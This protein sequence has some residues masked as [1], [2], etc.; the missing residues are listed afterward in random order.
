LRKLNQLRFAVK[1]EYALRIRGWKPLRDSK[2]SRVIRVKADEGQYVLKTLFVDEDRQR[3]I[4]EAEDYLRTQGIRIPKGVETRTGKPLFVWK[5]SP[6]VLQQW[7]CGKPYPLIAKDRV[8][9]ASTLLGSVHA[10]SLGFRGYRGE[11]YV[12]ACQWEEEYAADLASMKAWREKHRRL[13]KHMGLMTRI[14]LRDIDYFRK[15]A[16]RMQEKLKQNPYFAVWKE[17]PLSEHYLCHGDFHT[18]NVIARQEGSGGSD[19]G[20]N[21]GS[22]GSMLSIIDWE[23]VRYDFPS[24]DITRL[25]FVMMRRDKGWRKKRFETL[26]TAYLQVN[27]LTDEQKSLLYTDMAFPHIFERFLR[28]EQYRRM[29]LHE[30]RRFLKGERQKTAY[31]EHQIGV[32]PPS[33]FKAT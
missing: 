31:L 17:L 16:R 25:L 18:G 7:V 32:R 2:K 29:S 14:I 13:G 24:K 33:R 27:P 20:G 3:F 1:K 10:A 26:M 15:V 5:G 4:V 9:K 28:R 11:R 6:Y 19:R 23:D 21:G 30:V 12:G 22:G 8:K